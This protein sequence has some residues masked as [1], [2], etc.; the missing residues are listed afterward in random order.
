MIGVC[1]IGVALNAC[2]FGLVVRLIDRLAVRRGEA[3]AGGRASNGPGLSPQGHPH[4][5]TCAATLAPAR[6]LLYLGR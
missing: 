3:G 2:V 1:L 4:G 6:V 5:I